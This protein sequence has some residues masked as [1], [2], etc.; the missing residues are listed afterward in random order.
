VYSGIIVLSTIF[1]APSLHLFLHDAG[2][3][4]GTYYSQPRWKQGSKT[5]AKVLQVQE[6]TF[7]KKK[8]ERLQKKLP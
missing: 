7:V 6:S 1:N 3:G 5:L 2:R 8:R 4:S